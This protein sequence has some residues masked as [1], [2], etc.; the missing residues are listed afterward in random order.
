M[1][2]DKSEIGS[3]RYEKSYAR[4]ILCIVHTS[5]NKTKASLF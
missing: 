4:P 1:L 5:L 2:L 3:Q